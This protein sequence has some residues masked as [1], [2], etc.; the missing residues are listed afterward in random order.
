MNHKIKNELFTADS[1]FLRQVFDGCKRVCL[2]NGQG[3]QE[4]CHFC[5]LDEKTGEFS[6]R[7]GH[8]RAIDN[9]TFA[10]WTAIGVARLHVFR[11]Y[12][13]LFIIILGVLGTE[14]Q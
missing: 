6:S 8:S 4:S 12:A 10:G 5:G 1:W 3:E 2:I 9:R 13:L 14:T 11:E 7:K